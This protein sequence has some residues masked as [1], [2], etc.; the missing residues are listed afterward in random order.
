MLLYVRSEEAAVMH[1]SPW[2]SAKNYA[3]GCIGKR[4]LGTDYKDNLGHPQ[5]IWVSEGKHVEPRSLYLYQLEERK[6]NKIKVIR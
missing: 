6:K 2:V 1:F 4:L 3:V 5:G